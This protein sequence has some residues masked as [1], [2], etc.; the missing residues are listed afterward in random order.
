MKKILPYTRFMLGYTLIYIIT[1]NDIIGIIGFN[2]SISIFLSFE[3]LHFIDRNALV[4]IKNECSQFY[5]C[6]IHKNFFYFYDFIVHGLPLLYYCTCTNLHKNDNLLL[7]SFISCLMHL[8]WGYYVSNGTFK[9]EFI[10]IPSSRY[11]LTNLSW[12]LLWFLTC[13]GHFIL[14]LVN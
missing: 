9:L 14:P 11:I 12:Y 5:F 10:Y 3:S 4:L 13:I 6:K 1:N 8:T 7:L 2:S